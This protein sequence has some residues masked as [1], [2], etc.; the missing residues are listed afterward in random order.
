MDFRKLGPYKIRKR[1]NK[2]NYKLKLPTDRGRTIYPIFYISL[3]KKTDQTIFIVVKRIV[4]E[5]QNKYKIKE[6]LN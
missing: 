3:L 6:I 5:E 2:I 1:I 4:K